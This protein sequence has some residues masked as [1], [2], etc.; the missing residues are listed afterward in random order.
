MLTL[1]AT[2]LLAIAPPPLAAGTALSLSSAGEV[3][4]APGRWTDVLLCGSPLG[5]AAGLDQSSHFLLVRSANGLTLRPTTLWQ[6]Q[7]P[8]PPPAGV[9]TVDPRC[10]V[11]AIPPG[12]APAAAGQAVA[13]LRA[14]LSIAPGRVWSMSR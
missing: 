3:A 2:L 8:A 5:A 6:R 9:A 11:I 7:Q 4:A 12:I 13:S 10:V 1:T 14:K